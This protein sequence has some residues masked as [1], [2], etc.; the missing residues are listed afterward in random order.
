MRVLLHSALLAVALPYA[1]EAL[2]AKHIIAVMMENHSFDNMLG[3][4]P[5]VDGV[6]G[7]GRCNVWNGKTF[8]A[9][10][11]GAFS[12]PDPDHS[13]SVSYSYCSYR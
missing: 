2:R 5:G 13:V 7:T 4:L 1:A 11:N 10:N 3:W 6:N 9:T 12:D 8:C